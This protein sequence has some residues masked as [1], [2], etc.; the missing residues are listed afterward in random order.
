MVHEFKVVLV[1][2]GMTGKTTFVK[3]HV[4]GEFEKRYLATLGVE[5]RNLKFYT[6]AGEIHFN[7]WDTAGQ[8]KYGGLRDG[9][10]IGANAGII[11][12]DVTSRLTYINIE[13]WYRD[14]YRICEDIPMVV[15]GNKID[16]KDRRVR[17]AQVRIPHQ[18]NLP[19]YEISAKSNYHIDLPFLCIAQKLLRD[20]TLHWTKQPDY[21]PADI[22]VDHGHLR[23][24]QE[25]LEKLGQ[26]MALPGGE[27]DDWA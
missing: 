22:V 9:Y 12:F 10:Y 24:Q 20:S 4:S 7:V 11:F 25:E 1:G 13:N 6:S 18:K 26:S 15:V 23:A 14:L 17:A 5:V 3:R 8:E 21:I 27:E 16:S 19:Y 2:D